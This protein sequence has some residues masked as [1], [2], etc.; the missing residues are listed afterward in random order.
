MVS[1]RP[2]L[3]RAS[4]A[5]V[6]V[7]K[8]FYISVLYHWCFV[9]FADILD[10]SR[11]VSEDGKKKVGAVC[12]APHLGSVTVVPVTHHREVTLAGVTALPAMLAARM[13]WESVQA[14]FPPAVTEEKLKRELKFA[15]AAVGIS[16]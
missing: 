12:K 14:A 9:F 6:A 4:T 7:R 15:C 5:G 2:V 16:V 13:E 1:P 8:F 3:G 11:V 10:T